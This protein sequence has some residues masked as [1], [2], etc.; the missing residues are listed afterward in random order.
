VGGVGSA[1]TGR[2]VAIRAACERI[3]EAQWAKGDPGEAIDDA[4]LAIET[5]AAVIW[6][7]R[8]GPERPE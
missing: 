6:D 7:M 4:T 2:L 3:A 1:V 5:A 8:H